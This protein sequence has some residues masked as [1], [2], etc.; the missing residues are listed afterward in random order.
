MVVYG[1]KS[2]PKKSFSRL[3]SETPVPVHEVRGC[4]AQTKDEEPSCGN[5][6]ST[7]G[8]LDDGTTGYSLSATGKNGPMACSDYWTTQRIDGGSCLNKQCATPDGSA[9]AIE[10]CSGEDEAFANTAYD[11][12]QPITSATKFLS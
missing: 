12:V 6:I 5:C 4:F 8:V 9:E 3:V 11:R 10:W 2:R 1:T 7:L